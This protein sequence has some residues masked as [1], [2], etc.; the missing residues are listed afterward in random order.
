MK[1]FPAWVS[2]VA[3]LACGGS[4]VVPGG[5]G[6]A[7]SSGPSG[8][9]TGAGAAGG[10]STSTST[11]ST[12]A[13][14]TGTTTATTTSTGAGGGGCTGSVMP[15]D[16]DEMVLSG[17]DMRTYRVHVPPSYAPTQP[18]PLVLVF[19]GFT[20]TDTSIITTTHFDQVADAHGF[21]VVFPQGLG[22][23]WDAG[24]C[25]P[26]SW[27]GATDDVKFTSDLIDQLESEL[28]IDPK[29]VYASGFSNGGMMSHRLACDLSD[30][31]AAI[32][33]VAGTLAIPSCTPS[34][35]VP[36]LHTHGTGDP[37]ANYDNGGLSGEQGVTS[38]IAEWVM[39]DGCT[40]MTPTNVYSMGD[41]SCDEYQQCQAGSVVQLCKVDQGGHQWPG[42]APDGIG[43]LTMNIDT[44]EYLA[45][46][47][48]QHPMP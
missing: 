44:S 42:G 12:T 36:V 41:V 39:I 1:S 3:L 40:D 18:T 2:T 22:N 15:G 19:H 45:Q 14:S 35:P 9:T 25:C 29:R 48:E 43:T 34:R 5:A 23:S 11:A 4:D 32:G 24:A 20:E 27:N 7:S 10:T 46:F 38:T 30:R 13:T 33:P 47:F 16:Y 8:A 31:I 6:G 26:P 21:V 28:C 37:I 17:S